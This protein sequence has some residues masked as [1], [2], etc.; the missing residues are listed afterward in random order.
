M[1]MINNLYLDEKKLNKFVNIHQKNRV[2]CIGTVA[3]LQFQ[4][5]LYAIL[6]KEK[7]MIS[8]LI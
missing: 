5:I 4:T 1:S 3:R 6:L 2:Y 7:I 8:N